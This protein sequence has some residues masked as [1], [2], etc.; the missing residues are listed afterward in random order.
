MWRQSVSITVKKHGVVTF[1]VLINVAVADFYNSVKAMSNDQGQHAGNSGI[2]TI[3]RLLTNNQNAPQH[4][5]FS[6]AIKKRLDADVNAILDIS[7]CPR[8]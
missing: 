3:D 8:F 5:V 2:V 4:T 6:T 7:R 1:S